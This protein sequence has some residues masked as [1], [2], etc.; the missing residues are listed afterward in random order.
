MTKSAGAD[1]FREL[2]VDANQQRKFQAPI[3]SELK[4]RNACKVEVYV[5][6]R[7][8]TGFVGAR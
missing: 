5:R 7:K 4:S 2:M 8:C 6:L 1:V 3:P